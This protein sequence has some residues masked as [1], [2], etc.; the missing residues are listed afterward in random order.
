MSTEYVTYKNFA[1][2]RVR[3]YSEFSMPLDVR[4]H[5]SRAVFLTAQLEAPRWGSVQS[6]DGAG[7]SAG[8][9]HNVAVTPAN[10]QQGSLWPLLA[11]VLSASTGDGDELVRELADAGW[12]LGADGKLRDAAGALVGGKEIRAK[13]TP[14]NGKVPTKGE[15]HQAA[16]RWARVFS[17]L[18][19]ARST[20]QAQAAFA[21]EWLVQSQSAA[22]LAVYRDY[23]PGIDSWAGIGIDQLSAEVELAMC[24]YHSF[25]ANAPGQ[26][27]KHLRE[28]HGSAPAGA[29]P[30]AKRLIRSL[31]RSPYGRWHDEPGVGNNRYD[32]TRLAVLKS[33]LWPMAAELMPRDLK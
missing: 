18:F 20:F 12:R 4:S 25:S 26:A 5:V 9:L 2:F 30:F 23:C 32:R 1:G 21:G 28:A 22:E 6:Y 11:R 19:G 7:M 3:G 13:L 31:G 15:A 14:P 24:V 27:V 10:M 8:L 33:R 16:E 29:T 17:E